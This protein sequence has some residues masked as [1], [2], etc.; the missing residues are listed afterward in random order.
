[1]ANKASVQQQAF[2]VG[3]SKCG[4]LVHVEAGKGGSKCFAFVQNGQ[5]AQTRLKPF[6]TN[7]FKQVAIITD[8]HTPFLIVVLLVRQC[9]A[10]PDAACYLVVIGKEP[11]WGGGGIKHRVFLD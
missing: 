3:I 1:M 10:A 5:P 8:G 6:Q 7:V 2:D 9:R 11:G 4:N